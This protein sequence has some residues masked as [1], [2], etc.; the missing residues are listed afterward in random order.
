[1]YSH[2][3]LLPLI[4]FLSILLFKIQF[5]VVASDNKPSARTAEAYITVIVIRNPN[6]PVCT[7]KNSQLEMS[8]YEQ[9]NKALL[10]I[11]ATDM[12]AATVCSH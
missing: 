12:D 5:T 11:T 10:R 2:C 7:Q 8:E 3:I 6:A 1:M 9:L 4:F